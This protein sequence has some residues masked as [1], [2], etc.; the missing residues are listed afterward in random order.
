MTLFVLE[1]PESW[2][3][4]VRVVETLPR[5][6]SDL[7]VLIRGGGVTRC[8]RCEPGLFPHFRQF[9][10]DGGRAFVCVRSLRDFGLPETRPPDLFE[11]VPDGEELIREYSARGYTVERL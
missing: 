5:D 1:H 10:L 2:E 6:K 4:F 9:V 7:A 11:R 3:R 8:L